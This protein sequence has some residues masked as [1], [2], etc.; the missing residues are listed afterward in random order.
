MTFLEDN[1]EW[2]KNVHIRGCYSQFLE[3]TNITAWKYE[4]IALVQCYCYSGPMDNQKKK[5][6]RNRSKNH[7]HLYTSF[8]LSRAVN[9]KV[10]KEHGQLHTVDRFLWCWSVRK[11]N[12]DNTSTMLSFESKLVSFSLGVDRFDLRYMIGWWFLEIGFLK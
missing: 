6:K 7:A 9:G 12:E 8:S 1:L 4:Q 2:K 5:M 10:C 11:L 3:R